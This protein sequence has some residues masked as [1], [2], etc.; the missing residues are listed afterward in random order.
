[1]LTGDREIIDESDVYIDVHKAIRRLTPAPKARVQRRLSEDPSGKY[2][3]IAHIKSD[4]DSAIIDSN[5]PS[6]TVGATSHESPLPSTSPKTATLMMRRSSAGLDGQFLKTTVPVRANF[7]DIKQHLKHLGPSNPATNPNKTRSTTVKIKP[8]SGIPSA[9]PRSASVAEPATDETPMEDEGDETTGLLKPQI[10]GK[11]GVQALR[12][13]YGSVSPAITVQLAP[14]SNGIPELILDAE[15]QADKATQTPA[16][17]NL[18]DL[19][20]EEAA[21]ESVQ[22]QQQQQRDSSPA[23]PKRQLRGSSSGESA[24]STDDKKTDTNTLILQRPYVRSG[25]I[26][27]NVIESRG[28]RKV[29]LETTSSN[30][31]EESAVAAGGSS[32]D[33]PRLL[34]RSTFG[35]FGRDRENG[36]DKESE[37]GKEDGRSQPSPVAEEEEDD[38]DENVLSPGPEDEDEP[39]SYAEA[40]AKG[41][42]QDGQSGSSSGAGKKKNRRKKRKGGKS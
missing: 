13:T 26:T 19:D 42:S 11:D 29:V 31:D 25:S 28:V 39:G 37:N 30:D 8:G 41:T 3:D 21:T 14:Q 1:V 38:D 12:Q 17:P 16:Q 15:E 24:N 2:T 7:Q 6:Q 36:K 27:E 5:K 22:S 40:A 9:H 23:Q 33:Q 4:S 32:P 20:S 10:S 34:G 18:I 35:L